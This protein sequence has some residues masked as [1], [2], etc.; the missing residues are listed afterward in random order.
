VVIVER[1]RAVSGV[2]L[3]EAIV[4]NGDS[5]CIVVRQRRD[6]P[7]LLWEDLFIAYC[8]IHHAWYLHI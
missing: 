3:G 7:K 6:L 8:N 2:N 4:T 5:C 1:E